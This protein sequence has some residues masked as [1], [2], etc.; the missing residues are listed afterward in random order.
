MPGKA[1][2]IKGIGPADT[3]TKAQ[4][5]LP[6]RFRIGSNTKTF[7]VTVLLQLQ[8]EHLLK[9]DDPISK[10]NI[11]VAVPNGKNITIRQLAE[12]RSGLLKRMTLSNSTHF[13]SN[14]I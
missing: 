10:F 13:T 5:E 8:D 14:P 7:V 2:Y 11:G 1:P 12:M 9:M 3:K 4:F 6:D